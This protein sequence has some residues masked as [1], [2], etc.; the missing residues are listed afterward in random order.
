MVYIMDMWYGMSLSITT[1]GQNI[2]MDI[3]A[4]CELDIYIQQKYDCY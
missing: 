4:Y 2:A 3:I 1:V